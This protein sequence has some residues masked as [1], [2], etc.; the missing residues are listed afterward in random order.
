[1]V[2]ENITIGSFDTYV[3]LFDVMFKTLSSRTVFTSKIPSYYQMMSS[4]YN[5]NL[6]SHIL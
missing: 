2:T 6:L 1:M 4:Q 3:K 5:Q